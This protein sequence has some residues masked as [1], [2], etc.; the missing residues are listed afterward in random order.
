M[1]EKTGDRIMTRKPNK[2]RK[3]SDLPKLKDY[4]GSGRFVPG[5]VI[6]LIVLAVLGLVIGW[7]VLGSPLLGLLL[8]LVMGGGV[9]MGMRNS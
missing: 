4:E 2:P 3:L 6:V 7:L 1:R 8:G 9:I 5:P